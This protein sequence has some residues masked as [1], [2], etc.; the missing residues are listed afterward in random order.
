MNCFN[1]RFP[2]GASLSPVVDRA[3]HRPRGARRLAT[4]ASA[5]ALVSSLATG[6][7]DSDSGSGWGDGGNAGVGQG[8]AQ[9]F[10]QFRQI[11]EEGGIPGP[12]TLDDVGFFNE[13]KIELP[14]PDCGEDVCIHGL[15][16]VMGNMIS[17]SNC[18]VVLLGMNTPIDPTQLERP[19]L[20]L[21]LV[22]DV[23]G[24]MG[25]EKIA[26][27]RDGLER[28]FFELQ[29]EDRINLV[30]FG[31]EATILAEAVSPDDAGLANAV[32]GLDAEGST[33]LYDG[34]RRGYELATTHHDV[35]RQNRL[36]LL[37]DG[38]A[39]AGITSDAKILELAE[40]YGGEGLTLST[41]GL[42]TDF[43]PDLMRGLS[44]KGAGAFYFVEEPAAVREVF[45]E[46]ANA[47][48]VPLAHRVELDLDVFAGYDLRRVYGTK[49]VEIV[50]NSAFIEIPTLQIAHRTSDAPDGSG[51]RGG[52]GAILAELTPTGDA[53]AEVGDILFA[54]EKPDGSEVV[55]QQVEVRSPLMPWETPEEG[56]FADRSVEKSFVMLNLFV[57][58]KMAAERAEA[59]DDP[60][61]IAVLT[62]LDQN[63]GD[64][65]RKNDDEDI[66]DDL[67][68]VRLFIQNLEARGASSSRPAPVP[69]PWPA[70]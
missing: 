7:G 55:T 64:W 23:S 26:A 39:T 2:F 62:A 68:Y 18:T 67:V 17:G 46:E 37:S 59:G 1:F 28:M 31:S 19:P 34:L 29:P 41:I 70:D 8:G 13:H 30:A 27:L 24:S 47:F 32:A 50:G 53:P 9:D 22:V 10:G 57:G 36:L 65:E 35:A 69:E 21:T 42:G 14:S 25:G 43:D 11:L 52:G 60:G 33:N 16:G 4:M 6:C 56:F 58:F 3:D 61:A 63:V 44:E 45:V 20:N 15:L 5:F 38:V 48:L 49:S 51:R 40:A 54:Y 12:E 66:A